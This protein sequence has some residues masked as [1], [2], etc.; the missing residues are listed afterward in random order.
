MQGW[1]LAARAVAYG[2]SIEYSGPMYR[3][4]TPDPDGIR[5]W[6]DHSKGM[7]ARGGELKGFQIAGADKK[8]V[9][10]T[11]RIDGDTIVVSGSGIANPVYVRY[12]WAAVPDA[13]LFNAAGLPASPFTSEP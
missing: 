6:F 1:R 2:E 8:Y 10:A 13:N 7:V 4:V 11:A 3:M 12:A 5:V 9:P